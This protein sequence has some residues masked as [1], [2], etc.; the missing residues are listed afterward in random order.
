MLINNWIPRNELTLLESKMI[1][2]VNY[3][4]M[5]FAVALASGVDVFPY[6]LDPYSVTEQHREPITIAYAVYN[7]SKFRIEDDLFYVCSLLPWAN[8]DNVVN[9]IQNI[10]MWRTSNKIDDDFGIL[11]KITKK[12]NVVMTADGVKFF[13]IAKDSDFLIL[14]SF[15]DA[16]SDDFYKESHLT[17]LYNYL[18]AWCSKNNCTMLMRTKGAVDHQYK[19]QISFTVQ[20]LKTVNPYLELSNNDSIKLPLK[21]ILR[22]SDDNPYRSF[23]DAWQLARDITDAKVYLGQYH[24]TNLYLSERWATYVHQQDIN[25]PMPIST[26]DTI[27][28]DENEYPF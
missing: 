15:E 21:R 5:Q 17:K 10:D 3:L 19:N 8:Y 13:D 2:G 12:S 4:E 28:L 26:L 23:S 1:E 6:S 16:T 11:F 18:N 27:Q 25:P 7:G 14:D 20:D 24:E 22:F 9:R